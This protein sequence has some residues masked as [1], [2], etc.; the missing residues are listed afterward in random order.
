MNYGEFLAKI[1]GGILISYKSY[2]DYQGDHITI[3]ELGS[4]WRI[5]KGVYGSCSGCDWLESTQI[6]SD[7]DLEKLSDAPYSE[8]DK[9]EASFAILPEAKEEYLKD[10]KPFLI[11][12]KDQLPETLEDFKALL[13]ANTRTM[14]DD[15]YKEIDEDAAVFEQMTKFK[16]DNLKY[17]EGKYEERS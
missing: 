16:F 2:G 6:Y 12:P 10:N 9:L 7:A 13:P 17:L 5:Y 3:L 14:Q 8:H 4:E 11:I 15:D 1:T